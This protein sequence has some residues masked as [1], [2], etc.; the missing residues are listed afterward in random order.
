MAMFNFAVSRGLGKK[1]WVVGLFDYAKLSDWKKRG[2]QNIAE[3]F[4]VLVH[5][6]VGSGLPY[7]D[8][9]LVGCPTQE[10]AEARIKRLY[11]SEPNI[12][13]FVSPLRGGDTKTL[14]LARNEVREWQCDPQTP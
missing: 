8:T 5:I 9:Y 4:V 7:H 3:G 1:D 6:P 11:P 12:K 14:K 10:E 13:L 2:A